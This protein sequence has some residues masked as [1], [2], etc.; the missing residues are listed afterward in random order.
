MNHIN[1]DMDGV[2]ADFEK[3]F[4]DYVG[5]PTSYFITSEQ[6]WLALKESMERDFFNLYLHL[7][8]KLDAKYLVSELDKLTKNTDITVGVLTGIPK[9]N[10]IPLA[11]SHKKIYVDYHFPTLRNRFKIGPY[12]EDKWK[13]C[14]NKDQILIDD[15]TLNVHD[16][17][18][19]GGIAIAHDNA[20]KTLAIVEHYITHSKDY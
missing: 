14:S 7:P 8:L 19:A 3:N 10:I 18:R 13:H 1:L 4:L 15:S 2:L 6:R 11:E 20:D 5:L 9:G 12:S 16:W 17:K